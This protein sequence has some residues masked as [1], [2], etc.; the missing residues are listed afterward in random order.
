MDWL[1]REFPNRIP[2]DSD[3]SS[4]MERIVVLQLTVL[5]ILHRLYILLL[6]SNG[7]QVFRCQILYVCHNMVH[8]LGHARFSPH[9]E[10][11]LFHS[12]FPPIAPRWLE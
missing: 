6:I 1:G 3:V 12:L 7:E 5:L 10:I 11:Q 4:E 8:V 9:F 2:A